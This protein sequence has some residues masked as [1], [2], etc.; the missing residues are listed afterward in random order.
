MSVVSIMATILED[1]LREYGV[2]NLTKSTC[3]TIVR[4]VI[5]RTAEVAADIN[6]SQLLLHTNK[7]TGDNY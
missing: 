3:E 4:S 7:Q 6:D 1:E 5:R 2:L